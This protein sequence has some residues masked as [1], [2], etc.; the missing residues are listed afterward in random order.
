VPNQ[1]QAQRVKT[2]YSYVVSSTEEGL[3]VTSYAGSGVHALRISW[4]ELQRWLEPPCGCPRAAHEP[5]CD[6]GIYDLRRA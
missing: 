3:V 4:D 1:T 6:I 2:Q 5:W